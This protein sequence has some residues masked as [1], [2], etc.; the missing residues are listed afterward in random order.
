MMSYKFFASIARLPEK[1]VILRYIYYKDAIKHIYLHIDC[2]DARK[3]S[4]N[5]VDFLS[6]ANK[7]QVNETVVTLSIL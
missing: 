7:L 4:R 2:K 1:T 6:E 5:T 3:T